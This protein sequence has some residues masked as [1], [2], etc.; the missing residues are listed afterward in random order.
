MPDTDVQLHW[1]K[2]QSG[3]WCGLDDLD[4]SLIDT[5]SSGVYIIWH[6]GQRPRTVRVGQGNFRD[7]FSAHRNDSSVTQYRREGPLYV[8]WAEVHE[9]NRDG[10]EFY[11]YSSLRPLVGTVSWAPR[12]S[13]NLPW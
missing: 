6:G 10:V 7:R 11:L 4:L 5:E 12:L 1:V 3:R 2:Y 13:A 9:S 8:T